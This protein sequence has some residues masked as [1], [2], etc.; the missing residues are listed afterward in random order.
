MKNINQAAA[1]TPASSPSIETPATPEKTRV[2][3]NLPSFG[4]ASAAP[5]LAVKRVEKFKTSFGVE[6]LVGDSNTSELPTAEQHFAAAIA[7]AKDYAKKNKVALTVRG[8][9]Y[10]EVPA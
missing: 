8:T 2:Q 9:L 7:A 6:T 10:W 4:L 5:P 1:E 3:R